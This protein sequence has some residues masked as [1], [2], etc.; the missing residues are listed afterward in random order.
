MSE[1]EVASLYGGPATRRVRTRDLILAKQR[2][3][4][5]AMLTSYDQYTAGRPHPSPVPCACQWRLTN[6]GAP[7]DGPSPP[8]ADRPG[9]SA[10]VK[11]ASRRFA[12]PFGHP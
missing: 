10:G 1:H 8:S 12:M 6:I 5:W 4:R 3:E 2:G 7:G 11:G 9:V